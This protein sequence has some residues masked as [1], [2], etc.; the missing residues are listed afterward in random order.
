KLTAAQGLKIESENH[1]NHDVKTA[2]VLRSPSE[3]KQPFD[4][5]VVASKAI[6]PGSTPP[7]FKDV[8]DERTTFVLIQNG[9]GNEDPFREFY[10]KCSI[11]SCVTW[12]GAI[13]KTPGVITHTKNE[14]MQMGLFSNPDL[15][16]SLEKTRLDEFAS[17]LKNGGTF[18]SVEEN[19]QIKRW[20]K[21][22]WNAAWNPITTLTM[23]DTQT[24]LKSSPEAMEATKRLMR[25]MIDVAQRCGVPVEYELVDRLLDKVLGMAGVYSSMYVDM[26]ENRPMEVE[27]ILGSA[28]K[29][30]KEFGMDIPVLGAVYSLVTAIDQRIRNGKE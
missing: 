29:R 22:V 13:Q 30:A 28:V 1:G 5:I 20:E 14:D 2:H 9:V 12:V 17:L 7:L 23:I 11:I 26:K 4:Y 8:V 15:D 19:I 18:F 24:W 6:D 27:I 3:A 10:P 25:E 21:V 16:Q